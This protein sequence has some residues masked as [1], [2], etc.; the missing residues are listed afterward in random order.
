[1]NYT[2]S[3]L[4]GSLIAVM[5]LMNGILA[6]AIGNDTSS[7]V[8]HALGLPVIALIMLI[9]KIG[10]QLKTG[11]PLYLYSA[12]ALG[13]LTVVFTNYSFAHLG[14]SLPVALGLFGQTSSS[15]LIDRYGWLGV[16]P[17]PFAKAKLLGMSI[18]LVGIILMMFY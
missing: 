7:I 15:L 13:F 4:T 18:T 17:R 3:T 6:G 1:M 12:G 8:I 5:I 2:L 16:K 11:L 10:P 9:K 14:V